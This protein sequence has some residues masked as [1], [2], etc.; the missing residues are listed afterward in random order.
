MQVGYNKQTNDKL[1]NMAVAW[2][3]SCAENK[4]CGVKAKVDWCRNIAVAVKNSI[5]GYGNYI[6]GVNVAD[7]GVGN[8]FSYGVQ[9]ELNM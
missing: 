6:F 3:R 7:F 2:D 9:V 5:P 4:G 8:R 1:T